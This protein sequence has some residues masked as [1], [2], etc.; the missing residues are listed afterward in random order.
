MEK[1]AD[2]HVREQATAAV[3]D[4][5]NAERLESLAQELDTQDTAFNAAIKEISNVRDFL[6]EP[7]HILGTDNTKHGEIAEN[8]EVGIRRAWDALNQ[9]PFSASFD[10]VGRTAPEDY[11]ISGVDVQ[12]KFINGTRGSLEHVIEHLDKYEFW[13]KNGEYFH[14]PKDQYDQAINAYQ[15]ITPDGLSNASAEKL[16]EK[17]DEIVS[18]TGRPFEDIVRPGSYEYREVQLRVAPETLDRDEASI[19]R[20][21]DHREA[22]ITAEHQPSMQ[23][24]LRGAAWGGVFAAG[25]QFSYGLY[26]KLKEGKKHRESYTIFDFTA[27]DWKELGLD[28]AKAGVAGGITGFVIYGFTNIA[29][30][31]APLAGAVASTARGIYT[32][33]DLYQSGKLSQGELIDNSMALGCEAGLVAICAAIGQTAIPVP[34]FGSIV[35]SV[36]GKFVSK[37]IKDRLGENSKT[38]IDWIDEKT[39]VALAKLDDKYHKL[40][41]EFM[42]EFSVLENLMISAFDPKL[43]RH[44]LSIK[45]AVEL[46]VPSSQIIHNPDDLDNFMLY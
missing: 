15:G 38:L 21:N 46:G 23:E 30:L 28:S 18:R 7:G 11:V 6:K 33:I 4:T 9:K 43:N 13:G 36:V 29:S 35:G 12:S 5:L 26:K 17:I 45:V 2:L 16:R 19:D 40:V 3:I 24:T 14:I 8:M 39:A 41:S 27:T 20:E 34:V 42:A 32:Q 22:E 25:L 10:D 1:N 44:L 37:I 31:P